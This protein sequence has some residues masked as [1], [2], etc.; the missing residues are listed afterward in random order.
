VPMST[1]LPESTPD[2]VPAAR[3]YVVR[4][5]GCQMNVHDSE[6]M[7]G[8]LEAAGYVPA[9]PTSAAGTPR[10]ACTGTSDSSPP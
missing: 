7:A 9:D 6:H 2:A 5:L 4:T 3:T 1:T 8:M 10:P